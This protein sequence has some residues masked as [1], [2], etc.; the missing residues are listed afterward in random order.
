[1]KRYL[2]MTLAFMGTTACLPP[3]QQPQQF[4]LVLG[5]QP[6]PDHLKVNN[7]VGTVTDTHNKEI[8][9]RG[10]QVPLGY[11]TTQDSAMK[12]EVLEKI[13]DYGFNFVRVT[14][15]TINDYEYNNDLKVLTQFIDKAINEQ[16]LVMLEAHNL[17]GL[18]TNLD[19]AA[20][21]WAS[22]FPNLKD[23]Q[24]HLMINIANE[25]GNHELPM[26]TYISNYQDGVSK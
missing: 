25:W 20:K 21:Y 17:T 8:V 3:Q 22:L 12:P 5:K 24:D 9:L 19:Q 4:S 15:S 14:W 26:E 11:R 2:E 1:M 16:L 23:Y 7:K 6:T 18:N 10:V 13:A